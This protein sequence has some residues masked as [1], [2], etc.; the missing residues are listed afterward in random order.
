MI[1]TPGVAAEDVGF[2]C[3]AWVTFISPLVIVGAFTASSVVPSPKSTSR[4]TVEF[5]AT[6]PF[7]SISDGLIV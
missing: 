4:L 1:L 2:N 3:I 6:D 7:K 5:A